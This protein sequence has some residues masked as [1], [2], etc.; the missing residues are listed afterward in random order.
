MM[1]RAVML[2][3]GLS[4]MVGCGSVTSNELEGRWQSD[5]DK[6]LEYI[7]TSGLQLTKGQSDFVDKIFG[8]LTFDV[9]EKDVTISWT[10]GSLPTETKSYTYTNQ[11]NVY[12]VTIDGKDYI[13]TIEDDCMWVSVDEFNDD[14]R[15]Y[16]CRVE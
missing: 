15:E 9:R 3:L 10:D 6:T 5:K 2:L 7:Q 4:L 11:G 12:T 13:Y 1:K 8:K 14:M 16:F